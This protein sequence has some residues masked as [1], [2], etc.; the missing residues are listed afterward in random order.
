MHLSDFSYDLSKELI[1][2]H[3]K[4]PRDGAKLMVVDRSTGKLQHSHFYD[5][6]NFLK[7]GDFIVFNQSE[8]I[9]ARLF[10]KVDGK[11]VEILL[12][13]NGSANVW[14]TMAKPGKRLTKKVEVIFSDKLK[15]EVLDATEGV[16]KLKFNLKGDDFWDEIGK[17]GEMP[18]PPYILKQRHEKHEENIDHKDYQTVYAKEKGSVAAPTAGLHFTDKLLNEIKDKGCDIGFVT[19]H[20]GLGTFEP[21]RTKKLEDH[22]IHSEH[23]ELSVDLANNLNQAKKEGRRIIAVG[24]TTVRVLESCQKEGILESQA[25]ETNIYIYPGYKFGFVEAMI[26]NFHLPKS[27]LLLLVSAFWTREK[28]LD[29]YNEAMKNNYRFY[30]YG[31]GMFIF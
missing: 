24:T 31:D 16:F 13:K 8:V 30:S 28:I 6:P 7:Q 19:L 12:V 1:A 11:E 9:P 21:I 10:G 17:I 5:L 27:S 2:T 3:P 15:A 20:V 23:F 18:L 29:I 4:E 26:T 14:E 25:G 22:K